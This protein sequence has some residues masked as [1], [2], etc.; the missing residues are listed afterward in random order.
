MEQ[1]ESS[2]LFGESANP[3]VSKSIMGR[4]GQSSPNMCLLKERTW[5]P[6]QWAW[7]DICDWLPYGNG[8]TRGHVLVPAKP[9]QSGTLI[10]WH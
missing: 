2:L 6:F 3:E 7:S 9:D 4:E 10:P 1:Q 8:A 5:L